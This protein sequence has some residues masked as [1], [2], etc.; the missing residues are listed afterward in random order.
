MRMTTNLES[1]T[2]ARPE[3]VDR[4]PRRRPGVPMLTKRSAEGTRPSDLPQQQSDVPVLVGV[5]VG[6]LTPIFGTTLPPRGVSGWL[7]RAA[8]RIP[9][10]KAARWMLPMLADRVEVVGGRIR[11]HPLITA[12]L[13][14]T[15][16]TLWWGRR[17]RERAR[18]H[19]L[20]RFFA[21]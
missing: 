8:Y 12:G 7:R 20:R 11:R 18:G 19:G 4:D 17:R 16:G 2:P 10:H 6:R 13:L 14:S 21:R 15:V 5:E 3:P 1:R 9:E